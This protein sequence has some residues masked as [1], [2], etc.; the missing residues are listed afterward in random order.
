[1]PFNKKEY[2]REYQKK[3]RLNNKD[4]VK[5]YVKKWSLKNKDKRKEYYLNNKEKIKEYTKKWRKENK[6]KWRNAI[7][8]WRLKPENK[9]KMRQYTRTGYVRHK[10]K[11][12]AYFKKWREENRAKWNKISRDYVRERRKKDRAFALSRSLRTRVAKAL[13]KK[14][15]SKL[16]NS[17][18]LI[19]CSSEELRK[20]IEEQFQEGMTWENYGFYGWHV[21]HIIPCASFDLSDPE[22]QKK[23]F[24]YTNL[25]PLWASD[26]LKKNKF[27]LGDITSPKM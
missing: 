8:N 16:N 20:Y 1:M 24:H 23:C 14:H 3:W 9:E 22:Q 12:L 13:K 26:N 21:D 7:R 10:A 25:Q 4:K 15:N 19:G 17:I 2:N 6:E 18:T 11:K 27:I 5:K